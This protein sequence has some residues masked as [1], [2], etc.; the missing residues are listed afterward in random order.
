MEGFQ[1]HRL[2]YVT[3]LWPGIP[4]RPDRPAPVPW[5]RVVGCFMWTEDHRPRHRGELPAGCVLVIG[6]QRAEAYWSGPL[7]EVQDGALR[8]PRSPRRI[9]LRLE[10]VEDE[11]P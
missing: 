6:P 8:F 5:E 4:H 7:P 10:W 1:V 3:R 9:P 11:T 2:W